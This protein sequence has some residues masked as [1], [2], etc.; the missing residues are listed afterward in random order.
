[1]R[2]FVGVGDL[3]GSESLHLLLLPPA[4]QIFFYDQWQA[5]YL[6]NSLRD[7][8]KKTYPGSEQDV[9]LRFLREEIGYAPA[10]DV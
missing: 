7:N 1:M 10:P 5:K 4:G 8:L 6:V 9:S 3:Y 2:I